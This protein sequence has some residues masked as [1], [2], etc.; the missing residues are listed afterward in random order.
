LAA[1]NHAAIAAIYSFEEISG[2]HLL[3]QEHRR[4]LDE[5]YLVTGLR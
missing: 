5:L 4:S 2:R 3:V 1:V